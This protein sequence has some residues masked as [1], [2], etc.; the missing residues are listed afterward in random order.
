MECVCLP[1]GRP[2]T[3]ILLF[4]PRWFLLLMVAVG[5]H[6][7]GI[8]LYPPTLFF[9]SSFLPSFL[10]CF[11]ILQN[12]L[13]WHWHSS[14]SQG[15]AGGALANGMVKA[16]HVAATEIAASFPLSKG[17]MIITVFLEKGRQ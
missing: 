3:D 4:M 9:F 14:K 11:F 7:G 16:S 6:F 15:A 10:P 12:L 5:G 17:E 13:N 2:Y 1:A 8:I